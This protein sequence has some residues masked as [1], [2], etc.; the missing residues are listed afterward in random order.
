[1]DTDQHHGVAIALED[2]GSHSGDCPRH[3]G[4]VQDLL[5]DRLPRIL[6]RHFTPTRLIQKS[7]PVGKQFG[8]LL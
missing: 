2:F 3:P 5:K 6:R 1:M 7:S 8:V 4:L